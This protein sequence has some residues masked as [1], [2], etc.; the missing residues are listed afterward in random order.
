M[1]A[2][3]TSLLQTEALVDEGEDSP[4]GSN[5]EP[6]T[7]TLKNLPPD[8]H[9]TLSERAERN[10]RSLNGEILA[11]LQGS[12]DVEVDVDLVLAEADRFVEKLSFSTTAAEIARNR[13]AGRP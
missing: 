2:G 3:R 9:K 7:I 5:M 1:R 12:L 13:N 6:T 10:H 11:T 8:L 4:Y